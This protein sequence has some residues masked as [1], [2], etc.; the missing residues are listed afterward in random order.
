MVP[1]LLSAALTV[2][3]YFLS[4]PYRR[5]IYP[6]LNR[7]LAPALSC[8]LAGGAYE[9]TLVAKDLILAATHIPQDAFV[10]GKLGCV[11]VSDWLPIILVIAGMTYLEVRRRRE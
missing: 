6:R 10:C 9:A 5:A 11:R 3:F 1:Y 4:M 8:I 7:F 2:P